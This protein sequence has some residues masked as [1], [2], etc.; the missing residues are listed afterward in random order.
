V[1]VLLDRLAQPQNIRRLLSVF[2]ALTVAALV[3]AAVAIVREFRTAE[4]VE[5][6]TDRVTVIERPTQPTR[7]QTRRAL[8]RAIDSLAIRQR[9]A[10]LD[11]L[12]NAATLKQL[13][14]IRQRAK[15]VTRRRARQQAARPQRPVVRRSPARGRV[16]RPAP[17]PP[18]PPPVVVVP[19]PVPAPPPVLPSPAL[20]PAPDGPGKHGRGKAKG[21][22]K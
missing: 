21:H 17:I 5:Q 9:R 8:D 19:A 14:R 7:A 3:L 18:P 11:R 15:V 13:K 22:S 16:P 1:I 6:V 10:L 4:R 2:V 20:T 12:L